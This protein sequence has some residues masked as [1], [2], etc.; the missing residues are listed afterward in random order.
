MLRSK[1]L[2]VALIVLFFW[3]YEVFSL[4]D[5]PLWTAYLIL[6]TSAPPL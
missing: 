1:W 5:H 3:A 6:V 4:W 2:A